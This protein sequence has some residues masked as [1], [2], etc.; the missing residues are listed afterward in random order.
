MAP[1]GTVT[2]AGT[3]RALVELDK[4]TVV[5]PEGAALESPTVQVVLAFCA[6]V[7]ALHCREEIRTGATNTIDVLAEELPRVALMVAVWPELIVPVLTVKEAE[8]A[9]AATV[10]EAGTVRR[11]VLLATETGMPPAGAAWERTTVQEV[12]AFCARLGATH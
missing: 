5:P 11:A 7:I 10:T 8:V 3:V 9:L 6:R 1:A 4:A 2:D 12:L